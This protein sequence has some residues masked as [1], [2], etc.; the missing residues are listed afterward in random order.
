KRPADPTWRHYPARFLGQHSINV[1]EAPFVAA[2]TAANLRGG[3]EL[4]P[5]VGAT[6]AARGMF[7][8]PLGLDKYLLVPHQ[9][10]NADRSRSRHD[11]DVKE[12]ACKRASKAQLLHAGRKRNHAEEPA[13]EPGVPLY[14]TALV[15][16]L[17]P[18]AADAV[19]G[20]HVIMMMRGSPANLKER[21][22]QG[23]SPRWCSLNITVSRNTVS[24]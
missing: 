24:I 5:G 3:N 16:A 11:D 17:E 1:N 23:R 14:Q 10:V 21:D 2:L 20:F 19:G 13:D 4:E 8:E 15:P 6:G 7:D 18:K 12:Q 9:A 22:H